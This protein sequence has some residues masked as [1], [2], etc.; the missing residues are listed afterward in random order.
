MLEHIQ[1][2]TELGNVD[3]VFSDIVIPPQ[4]TFNISGPYTTDPNGVSQVPGAA[5]YI[6]NAPPLPPVSFLRLFQGAKDH[7]LT[8]TY[9]FWS[10]MPP[11]VAS[12][13]QAST[14]AAPTTAST[15][16]S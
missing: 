16:G 6:T 14:S 9:P 8:R 11:L 13:G 5:L 12:R 10:L 2:P 15:N 4:G 7:K 1:L 3:W